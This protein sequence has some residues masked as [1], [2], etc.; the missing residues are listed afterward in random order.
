MKY[1]ILPLVFCCLVISLLAQ[2]LSNAT[3]SAHYTLIDTD[4]D[5]TGNHDPIELMNAPFQG[6]DGVYNFGGYF[7]DVIDMDSTLIGTPDLPALNE[8]EFAIQIEV[9]FDELR[10]QPKRRNYSSSSK[11]LTTV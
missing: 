4:I 3:L 8:N 6:A 5:A 10:Q 11:R 9:R 1:L 7:Y 2:D